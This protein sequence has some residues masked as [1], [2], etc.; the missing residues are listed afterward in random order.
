[1]TERHIMKKLFDSTDESFEVGE[2]KYHLVSVGY[3][4]RKSVLFIDP[5]NIP[6][7]TITQITNTFGDNKQTVFAPCKSLMHFEKKEDRQ[8]IIKSVDFLEKKYL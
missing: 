3:E 4:P 1:M 5:A 8:A 7:V 6:L 2:F